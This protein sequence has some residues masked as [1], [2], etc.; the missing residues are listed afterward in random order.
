MAVSDELRC[1]VEKLML[2]AEV[3]GGI[4]RATSAIFEILKE[5]SLAH[6]MRIRPMLMHV[7][8][9]NRD[10]AGINASECHGLLDDILSLGWDWSQT[11]AVGIE[12]AST[13][14][15]EVYTFNAGL[16]SNSMGL[17]PPCEKS[18]VK[19]ASLSASHTNQVLRLIASSWSH[20]SEC[21]LVVNGKLSLEHLKHLDS[22]FADAA[23]NG[24][25]WLIISSEVLEAFP[26]LAAMIQEACN[27]TG[28]VQRKEHEL[29]IC[30]RIH[31]VW[32][33]AH[34]VTNKLVAYSDI[35]GKI[36]RSKPACA[37]ACPFMFQFL[38]KFGGGPNAEA[39]FETEAYVRG[40]AASRSMQPDM[41]DALGFESRGGIPLLRF[42]HA[43]LKA[44]YIMDM[45]KG[46][47]SSEIKR[48]HSMQIV[49]DAEA[50]MQEMRELISSAELHMCMA[51]HEFEMQCVLV[52][53]SKRLKQK[54]EKVPE[55]LSQAAL[56]CVDRIEQEHKVRVSG[57]WDSAN[58]SRPSASTAAASH[59]GVKS[60]CRS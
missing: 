41:W 60:L 40:R 48:M 49:K 37:A 8:P 25:N 13:K 17:L 33:H 26:G 51:V 50:L 46:I 54:D 6:Q 3:S 1:S 52:A 10:G 30:R 45:E 47:A 12:V 59:E 55:T 57:K 32:K 2:Q 21:P 14:L 38:L 18:T 42:R 27:A 15:E 53:F 16:V 43:V 31:T 36:L 29:Q 9:L 23:Q 39:F 34:G 22:A 44:C 11:H 35:K 4:V 28:Q 58:L 19:F 56:V 7:H 5:Q 20:A 24:L